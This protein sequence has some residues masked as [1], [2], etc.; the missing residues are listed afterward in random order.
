MLQAAPLLLIAEPRQTP[1]HPPFL[2]LPEKNNPQPRILRCQPPTRLLRGPGPARGVHTHPL[3]SHPDTYTNRAPSTRAHTHQRHAGTAAPL[4]HK[5]WRARGHT[6]PRAGTLA[7]PSPRRV[8]AAAHLHPRAPGAP[9]GPLLPALSPVGVRCRPPPTPLRLRR[10]DPRLQ[11]PLPLRGPER[12]QLPS[13]HPW[14][15]HL[16][17]VRRPPRPGP[18]DTHLSSA[19]LGSALRFSPAAPRTRAPRPAHL[20]EPGRGENG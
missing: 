17:Q 8:P 16:A 5:G 20:P 6:Q 14:P 4:P 13:S 12:P 9:W 15:A 1:P 18:A 10:G 7:V 2:C 19:A 11:H 3:S